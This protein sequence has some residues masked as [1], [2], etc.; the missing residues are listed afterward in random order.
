MQQRN[1]ILFV[2]LSIGVF[3]AWFLL[4]QPAFWPPKAKDDEKKQAEQKKDKAPV[5]PVT[6]QA[7]RELLPQLVLTAAPNGPPLVTASCLA[8]D[9]GLAELRTQRPTREQQYR[10]AQV[11]MEAAT[12]L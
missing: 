12:W 9:V 6:R 5:W 7:Q 2:L 8:V 11:G 4:I 1:F 3:A 10:K